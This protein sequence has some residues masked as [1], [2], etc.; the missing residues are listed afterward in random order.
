MK[1]AAL[2][3]LFVTGLSLISLGWASPAYAA[4]N[5][6][7]QA[8]TDSSGKQVNSSVCNQASA[9]GT[10]NP[11]L[12]PGG[13]ITKGIKVLGVVVGIVSVI[14]VMIGGFSYITSAGNPEKTATAKKRIIYALAG[15]MIAALAWAI[16]SFVTDRIL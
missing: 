13:P 1:K 16:V 7:G 11:L 12:G 4:Y 6:L 10:D 15:L 5:P 14:M 9:Q 2:K 8:C 3:M